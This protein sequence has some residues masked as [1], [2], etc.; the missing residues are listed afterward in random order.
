V[1]VEVSI[2]AL[3]ARRR[4]LCHIVAGLGV[5]ALL[6]GMV[7]LDFTGY[8][9]WLQ[10]LKRD[11]GVPSINIGRNTA[12]LTPWVVLAGIVTA[13]VVFVSPRWRDMSWVKRTVLSIVGL[14][15]FPL[16]LP[17]PW[18]IYFPA[19]AAYSIVGAMVGYDC[20]APFVAA[21]CLTPVG[22]GI[23]RWWQCGP[24]T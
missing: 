20:G 12:M 24:D 14:L 11:D 19:V 2:L 6:F 16:S 15:L 13:V 8:S 21:G 7:V 22:L 3:H 5:G 17:V 23:A 18:A 1:P 10:F 4:G 9:M